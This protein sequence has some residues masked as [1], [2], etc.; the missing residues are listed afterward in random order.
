MDGG[1]AGTG[2]PCGVKC[3]LLNKH[4]HLILLESEASETPSKSMTFVSLVCLKCPR[5]KYAAENMFLGNSIPPDKGD[6]CGIYSITH[7]QY[8]TW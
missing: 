1:L 4:S 8:T 6:V 5:G 7:T 3:D 2:L